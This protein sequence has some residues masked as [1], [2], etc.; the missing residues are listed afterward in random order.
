MIW[1]ILTVI[2]YVLGAVLFALLSGKDPNK[3]DDGLVI[4]FYPLTMWFIK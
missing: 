1:I 4:M 2:F 3:I